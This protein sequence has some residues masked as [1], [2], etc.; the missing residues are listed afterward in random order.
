MRTACIQMRSGVDMAANIKEASALIRK[1]AGGG[2]KLIATPEMTHVLQ[3]SSKHLFASIYTQDQDP[4][5]MAFSRL[6][7]E[8]N[9]HLLI[10]SLAIKTGSDRAAN[11]SFL[12][13]HDGHI[14]AHYDKIHLFDVQVSP[15]EVWK[16]SRIYDAGDRA[17]MA[18]IPDAKI[19]M[20][21]CYD[22]RFPNLYRHYAQSGADILMIPAA[23]TRVTGLAHWHSLLRARAIETGCYVMAPAQGGQHADGRETYGHSLIV[24]PWG[25]IIAECPDNEPGIIY[26]E[27]NM[28]AVQDVRRKIP[29][30]NHNPVYQT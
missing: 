23:F 7:K 18:N 2:A 8:L 29:A 17:V 25:E 21:I 13:G 14:I 22:L 4:G 1:A 12:F 15:E 10:G 24:N 27:L 16:E 26:A 5:V 6:A 9:V 30:W 3:R 20:S 11:R 19:G 28:K